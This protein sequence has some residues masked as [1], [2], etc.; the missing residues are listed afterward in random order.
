MFL[1]SRWGLVEGVGVYMNRCGWGDQWR[2]GQRDGL[3][4]GYMKCCSL[5]QVLLT[6]L[7]FVD[8]ARG[9]VDY[10]MFWFTR[11]CFCFLDEVLLR[12]WGF[13]WIDVVGVTSGGLVREMGCLSATWS[14]YAIISY[15]SCNLTRNSLDPWEGTYNVSLKKMRVVGLEMRIRV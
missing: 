13:T 1:F 8:C 7:G 10:M 12:E 9:F 6:V 3:F 15:T 14:V 11:W 5:C 2:F 4:V